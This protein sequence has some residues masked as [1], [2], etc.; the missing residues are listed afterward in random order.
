[1]SGNIQPIGVPGELYISGDGLAREYLHRPELTEEKFV[2]NPFEPGTRMYRTG[3]LARWQDDGTIQYLGRIDTQVKV[4]GFRIEIG[5]IEARLAEHPSIQDCAVI[6]RGEGAGKQLVAFYRATSEVPS[7]E[8]RAHLSKTLP[9]YMIPAAFV[10]LEAIPLSPN[11]KVDRRALSRM[12]VTLGASHEYVAPRNETEQQLVEIW[13]AVLNREPETIGVHDNFFELGGHSLLATQLIS[14]I[15]TQMEVELPLKTLFER[16]SVAGLAEAVAAAQK[17]EIPAIVPAD[18]TQYE[19]LPLS[20]AQERLWFINQL[21]PN[22]AGYN[23][24]GAVRIQG[25][26]DADELDRALN[27][28]IARHETLRTVFPSEDGRASQRILDRLDFRLERIQC[29]DEASAR[30][31]CR[32]D[33]VTPFDLANGPLIR[34]KVIQFAADEHVLMLNMHHIV[35]D[36]WSLGVLIQELAAI[37]NGQELPAL[38]IQYADYSIWQRQ[39]LE[40][41]G[42]LDRQ[43]AYWRQKLAGVPESL[44][45]PTDHARPS[46]PN[47]AGATHDF[48]LDAQ[49]A[50]Q[51]QRLAEQQGATLYMVLLA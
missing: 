30:E 43:L 46:M 7:D 32:A 11:G 3:D 9:D 36:G 39:W 44:D 35:S 51:L 24:P 15:R 47:F 48:A 5:E 4:R 21:E 34:G 29:A 8:L 16:S 12:D 42:A 17:T 2:A 50:S 28:I 45:L 18:R 41:S 13:S 26:L 25:A 19:R 37:M 27:A 14:K 49:V 23:V 10:G 20:F 38:P 22:S 31:L 33:A 40:E 6:A 1:A